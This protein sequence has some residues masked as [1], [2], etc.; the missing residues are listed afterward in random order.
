MGGC[1][2]HI[3]FNTKFLLPEFH[4]DMYNKPARITRINNSMKDG[5]PAAV[6][7]LVLT[8]VLCTFHSREA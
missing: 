1:I 7:K 2:G 8:V 4:M 3:Y 6:F 5:E